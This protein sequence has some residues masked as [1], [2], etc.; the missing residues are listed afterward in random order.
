MYDPKHDPKLIVK[1]LR[2]MRDNDRG[3]YYLHVSSDGGVQEK[4]DEKKEDHLNLLV[5]AGHAERKSSIEFKIT[6]HGYDFL[7]A[8][9]NDEDVW[10]KFLEY[11]DKGMTYTTAVP[12]VM[13]LAVEANT[14]LESLQPQ[15]FVAMWFDA[16]MEEAYTEGIRPAIEDA[17]YASF[18]IDRKEHNNRIDGE[19]ISEIRRSRFLVA[20]FSQGKDGARGGVYYEAGFAHGLNIPVIFTCRKDNLDDLHFDTRQYK[21][22]VWE[23]PDDLRKQLLKRITVTINDRPMAE[24]HDPELIK[25]LRKMSKDKGRRLSSPNTLDGKNQKE[26]DQLEIL[27]DHGYAKWINEH[28]IRITNDGY[29]F[30]NSIDKNKDA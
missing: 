30:L 15:A 11:L 25:L 29:D 22:I 23:T 16:S 12:K 10:K 14:H 3:C 4:D 7:N 17:G 24:I 9:D 6:I 28:V 1:L 26:R 21:H 2:D 20:D 5:V 8:I 18:R 19:I 13:E 27:A